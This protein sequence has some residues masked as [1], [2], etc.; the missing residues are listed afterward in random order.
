MGLRR[1]ELQMAACWLM[2]RGAPQRGRLPALLQ[3]SPGLILLELLRLRA[4]A[5]RQERNS[6]EQDE[7]FDPAAA[8]QRRHC[9]RQT[10]CD[11]AA[12]HAAGHESIRTPEL[13][14][15]ITPSR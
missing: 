4:P 15:G 14:G 7:T 9:D 5:G 8:V 2:R 3:P 1:V 13:V 6:K 10:E 11:E 12:L